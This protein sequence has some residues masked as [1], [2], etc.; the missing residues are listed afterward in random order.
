MVLNTSNSNDLE[1][2][3]LK[4]LRMLC[5]VFYF[6]SFF[7]LHIPRKICT[8]FCF[9]GTNMIECKLY[10]HMQIGLSL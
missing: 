10:H 9:L 4:G 3:A 6:I 2:L 7:L 8:H 5:S 1:Q